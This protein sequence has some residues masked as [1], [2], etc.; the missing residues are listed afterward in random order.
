MV[1]GIPDAF[2]LDFT[3]KRVPVS[4]SVNAGLCIDNKCIE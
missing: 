2:A 1:E 4:K 3:T